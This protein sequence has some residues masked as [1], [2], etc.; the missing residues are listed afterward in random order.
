MKKTKKIIIGVLILCVAI[1]I[2][3]LVIKDYNKKEKAKIKAAFSE[4]DDTDSI[5]LLGKDLSDLNL[6]KEYDKL[7][8]C[9][10]D[11]DTKF[12]DKLPDNFDPKK[13]LNGG[14]NETLGLGIKE[15]HE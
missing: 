14:K 10:F 8:E 9:T 4:K 11:T 13:I 6:S 1:C 7:S 15:L 12:P 5:S 2:S 3:V